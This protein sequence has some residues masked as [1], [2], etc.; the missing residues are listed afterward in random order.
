MATLL[1]LQTMIV[2]GPTLANQSI[3]VVFLNPGF[4]HGFWGNVTS[5][6]EAAAEDLAVNLEVLSAD[7]DRIKMLN[8]LKDVAGRSNPPDYAVIV[9]ELQQGPIMAELLDTAG[10]PYFFLLN[11]LSTDQVE[12]LRNK[13][14][15]EHYIGSIAPDNFETGYETAKALINNVTKETG[16]ASPIKVL[17]LLGDTATPAA[18]EREAG[19]R[20]AVAE[21]NNAQLL[22]AFSVDWLFD[23]AKRAV[24]QFLLRSSTDVIWT[25]SGPIAFGAIE[26]VEEAGLKAGTDVKFAGVGWFPNALDAVASKTMVM[27]YGGYFISGAWSMVAVRDFHDGVQLENNSELTAPLTEVNQDNIAQF[28]KHIRDID[29]RTVDFS[30]FLRSRTDQAAYDFSAD[31]LLRNISRQLEDVTCTDC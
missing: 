13:D 8:H 4:E 21:T 23:R 25:A 11:R 18:V 2:C 6:M 20:K 9:N 3:D 5:T 28:Q 1:L 30:A 31:I 19:M 14:K 17:A 16:D 7:R 27:T 26:A 24:K 29:W 15:F 22:R 12:N 10:I